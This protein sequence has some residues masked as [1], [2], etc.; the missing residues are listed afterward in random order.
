MRSEHTVGSTDHTEQI[1]S[2]GAFLPIFF[3]YLIYNQTF[4]LIKN[5]EVQT[6]DLAN[7]IIPPEVRHRAQFKN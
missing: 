6:Q 2:V 1:S 3:T 4:N 7:K 5:Q